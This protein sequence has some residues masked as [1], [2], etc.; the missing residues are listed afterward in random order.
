M[1]IT[2]VQA[3]IG[4]VILSVIVVPTLIAIGKHY[5]DQRRRAKQAALD[6]RYITKEVHDMRFDEMAA[7]QA[8]QHQ[9]NRD[10]LET[11]RSEALL[12]E[13]KVLGSIEALSSQV[14]EGEREM[15][16]EIGQQ[17]QRV[18]EV[19]RIMITGDRRQDRPRG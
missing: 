12:R 16:G 3:T 9:E 10:F 14:R 7:T 4:A 17:S 18:D 11:I 5:F 1:E 13:G 2:P 15:R 19:L 8:Q 6:E